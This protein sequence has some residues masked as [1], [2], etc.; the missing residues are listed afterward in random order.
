MLNKSIESTSPTC[1]NMAVQVHHSNGKANKSRK[2]LIPTAYT[3][4][5]H[6]QNIWTAGV[7]TAMLVAIESMESLSHATPTSGA[8][9]NSTES[10][11]PSKFVV[12]SVSLFGW[13]GSEL[14]NCGI[15]TDAE[16]NR[17]FGFL[18][19]DAGVLCMA[20]SCGPFIG[21]SSPVWRRRKG[22]SHVD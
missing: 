11:V 1:H 10:N 12:K 21:F 9:W 15:S 6:C 17:I 4:D 3:T 8:Q 20:L 13:I 7:K 2:K 16:L 22:Q 19:T 5:N 14:A 18:L